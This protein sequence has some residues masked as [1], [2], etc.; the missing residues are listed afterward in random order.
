MGN[1]QSSGRV[2]LCYFFERS[3]TVDRERFSEGQLLMVR[4]HMSFRMGVVLN[5]SSVLVPRMSIE[6]GP[7][8][9]DFGHL[10]L[11]SRLR[12]RWYY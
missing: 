7:R 12:S 6:E 1:L 3:V 9:P 5:R 8:L 11:R 10:D 4:W 2:R